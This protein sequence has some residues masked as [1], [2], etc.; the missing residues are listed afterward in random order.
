MPGFLPVRFP[1]PL[2]EPAVPV[3]RQ[4]ALHGSCHQAWLDSVQGLGSCCPDSGTGEQS[5]VLGT[6][7]LQAIHSILR[8]SIT[9]AQARDKVKR[10]VSLLCEPPKGRAGR[11]SKSLTLDQAAAVLAASEGTPMHA[12]VVLS[13]LTGA[14]TDEVR[15]LR[16]D[17]VVA[18]DDARK[19]WLPVTVAGWAGITSGSLSTC[20]GRCAPEGTPRRR[21]HAGRWRCRDGASWRC[22]GTMTLTR[23]Q[24][25]REAG[26]CSPGAMVPRSTGTNAA[27]LRVAVV[28]RW[29]GLGEDRAA[30]RSRRDDD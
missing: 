6:R 11:P 12:Y 28:G 3:S 10:N 16:W 9:L 4:R 14:R 24:H 15:A 5:R 8:R 18:Y 1:R 21:S 30:C 27:Q 29:H 13:L 20:G 25:A 22:A 17:H 26:Q 23:W 2:A 19:A 7:S